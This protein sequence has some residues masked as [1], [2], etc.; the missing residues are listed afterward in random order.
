MWQNIET[1]YFCVFSIEHKQIM[2]CHI[3]LLLFL[4][5]FG[6]NKMHHTWKLS[7]VKGLS[8]GP[9]VDNSYS[10]QLPFLS[11][12]INRLVL[13]KRL[14]CQ[15]SIKKC[16]SGSTSYPTYLPGHLQFQISQH[17]GWKKIGHDPCT[18]CSRNPGV[19]HGK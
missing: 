3:V 19:R 6:N 17:H 8:Q 4:W 12:P 5:R 10:I 13:V 9:F 18:L 7:G 2:K 11:T 1:F 16:Q 14:E 15:S